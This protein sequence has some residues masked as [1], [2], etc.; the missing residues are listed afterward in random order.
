MQHQHKS[1]E[2][3]DHDTRRV[4]VIS[5]LK[6]DQTDSVMSNNHNLILDIGEQRLEGQLY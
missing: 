4:V 3:V 6:E 2:E 1:A 5:A